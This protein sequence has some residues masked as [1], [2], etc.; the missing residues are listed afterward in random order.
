MPKLIRTF[1]FRYPYYAN[2][3]N[4]FP[5][6]RAANE[7][8]Y[9]L[10][11]TLLQE[12][13]LIVDYE[14]ANFT[15]A[16]AI[17]PDPLANANIVSISPPGQIEPSSNSSELSKGAKA[18]IAVGC[19]ALASLLAAMVFFLFRRR[20]QRHTRRTIGAHGNVSELH[21]AAVSEIDSASTASPHPHKILSGTQEIDGTPRAELA[22]PF[23]GKSFVSVNEVP[24]ELETPSSTMQPRFEEVTASEYNSYRSERELN[25]RIASE[26]LGGMDSHISGSDIREYVVSPLEGRSIERTSV[27]SPLAGRFCK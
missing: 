2:A 5:I 21:G 11:R 19:V 16:Q 13:Y 23:P 17:F 9:T 8:Q 26:E 27:V 7:S 12:A 4:Y 1:A 20:R 14:R 24:Q 25:S 3:T 22:S 6:R 18:G 15:V 10:G